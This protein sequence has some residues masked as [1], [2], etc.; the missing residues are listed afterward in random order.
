MTAAR[1][2]KERIE[3]EMRLVLRAM[4]QQKQVATHNMAQLSRIYNDW[5]H[6]VNA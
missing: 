3:A 2:D 4:D 1:A 6:A 5:S